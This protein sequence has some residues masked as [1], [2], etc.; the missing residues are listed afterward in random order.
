MLKYDYMEEGHP[1]LGGT[2]VGP[3]TNQPPNPGS[4]PVNFGVQS[5]T[6]VSAPNYTTPTGSAPASTT[7][8]TPSNNLPI[9]DDIQNASA[10]PSRPTAINPSPISS[11]PS[12]TPQSNYAQEFM[13][14]V[15]ASTTSKDTGD[16]ILNN[17]AKT[18]KTHRIFLGIAITFVI[19]SIIAVI[20]LV[21]IT[22]NS[23]SNNSQIV[24]DTKPSQSAKEAFY[25]YANEILY[26]VDS[27]EQFTGD[28]TENDFAYEQKIYIGSDADQDYFDKIHQKYNSFYAML[29]FNADTTNLANSALYNVTTDYKQLLDF[30]A[31]NPASEEF[32]HDYI[33]AIYLDEGY[34]AAIEEIE[35]VLSNIPSNNSYAE[36]FTEIKEGE[37]SN[38]ATYIDIAENYG[39]ISG[40]SMDTTC[41]MQADEYYIDDEDLDSIMDAQSQQSYELLDTYYNY[42]GNRCW[43]IK[44][45]LEEE[46]Q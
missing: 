30:L 11:Q 38:V 23:K 33:I 44:S 2:G 36:Q 41:L 27:S 9:R 32:T 1:V 46:Y 14:S 18:K 17:G 7:T 21:L 19:I 43:Q 15:K 3:V 31:T 22:N 6:P 39:C 12:P 10:N 13:Q 35:R 4:E 40:D 5:N 16:I 29:S 42:I 8:P 26:G 45:L 20:A 24:Q 34:D 25:G 37:L 28:L